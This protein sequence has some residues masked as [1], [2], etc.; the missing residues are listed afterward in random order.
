[1]S[2]NT[3]FSEAGDN[4]PFN[5]RFKSPVFPFSNTSTIS[6]NARY[7]WD[8]HE[9]NTTTRKYGSFNNLRI[10]NGSTST[11]LVYPNGD[12]SQSIPIASG[13]TTTLDQQVMGFIS[14]LQIEEASAGSITANQIRIMV[15]KDLTNFESTFSRVHEKFFKE[16]PSFSAVDFL[17]GGSKKLNKL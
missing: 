9:L 4:R 8:F 5:R 12:T 11:I 16:K 3:F 10:Y 2:D 15:W 1:M 13:V 14:S 17:F 6:A 7:I